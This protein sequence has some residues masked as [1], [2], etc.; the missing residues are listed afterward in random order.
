MTRTLDDL[1][2][3]LH[4]EADA[5]AYPDVDA[6]VAGARRRVVASRRGRLAVLGAATAAVLVVGGLAVSRPA[7]KAL[8]QP[9]DKGP[10]TVSAS[11]ESFPEYQ[12]GMKL[13]TVVDAPM[14]ER[15]K[16]SII[17]PTTPA[18]GWAS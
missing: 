11:R 2:G 1:R 17:V 15:T 10:F 9:A 6:L 3:A 18:A 7:H 8:P 12:E 14:L 16:G 13:L 5:A 4:Q